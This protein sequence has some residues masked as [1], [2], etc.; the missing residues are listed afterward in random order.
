M[1]CTGVGKFVL[2]KCIKPEP[3]LSVQPSGDE[4]EGQQPDSYV[5]IKVDF[6]L[7]EDWFSDWMRD[8]KGNYYT[9]IE[10]LCS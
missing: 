3:K 5:E 8:P 2:D 6:E 4:D 7:L 9:I 10:S 1:I